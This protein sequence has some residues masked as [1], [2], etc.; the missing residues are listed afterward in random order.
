MNKNGYNQFKRAFRDA[1]ESLTDARKVDGLAFPDE[2]PST[3]IIKDSRGR[4]YIQVL[5]NN[6]QDGTDRAQLKAFPQYRLIDTGSEVSSTTTADRSVDR[7]TGTMSVQS[8][9]I[10]GIPDV[11]VPSTGS[12]GS[13]TGTTTTASPSDELVNANLNPDVTE[14]LRVI[15]DVGSR[16]SYFMD[17]TNANNFLTRD[18]VSDKLGMDSVSSNIVK[19]VDELKAFFF[20]FG[21]KI[22]PP[23]VNPYHIN[24]YQRCGTGDKKNDCCDQ[25][26]ITCDGRGSNIEYAKAPY[27]PH[28]LNTYMNCLETLSRTSAVRETS[29]T[30]EDFN[31]KV[32]QTALTKV[33]VTKFID[34][35]IDDLGVTR[36]QY[37]FN[38][39]SIML[40]ILKIDTKLF[41]I[42][43]MLNLHNSS[44]S[45]IT[46]AFYGKP[47][48]KIN[49]NGF[50]VLSDVVTST[51]IHNATLQML[52]LLGCILHLI[53]FIDIDSYNKIIEDH[54]SISSVGNVQRA[55]GGGS[56]PAVP[57]VI[58]STAQTPTQENIPTFLY[59]QL[60]S[61][62]DATR[63]VVN[64]IPITTITGSQYNP[65]K[66]ANIAY[67]CT[68]G[69]LAV[70]Q[71]I[72]GTLKSRCF[73]T[74]MSM[75]FPSG[76][77][78]SSTRNTT[79][80]GP[81]F[82]I[83]RLNDLDLQ[84][85]TRLAIDGIPLD[86]TK[87][88]PPK[89]IPNYL[90]VD[91]PICINKAIFCTI[92][93][94]ICG[95]SRFLWNS[96][97]PCLRLCDL[98]DVGAFDPDEPYPAPDPTT[99]TSTTS[100]TAPT[101]TQP[102]TTTTTSSSTT[103]QPPS[104]RALRDLNRGIDDDV[105][106]LDDIDSHFAR[107]RAKRATKKTG[108]VNFIDSRHDGVRHDDIGRDTVI[109]SRELYDFDDIPETNIAVRSGA[110]GG[111]NG[112]N[113]AVTTTVQYPFTDDVK[114][115]NEVDGVPDPEDAFSIKDMIQYLQENTFASVV[116]A[117][118]K[119]FTYL[120]L[121][122][123]AFASHDQKTFNYRVQQAS[124]RTVPSAV[125]RNLYSMLTRGVKF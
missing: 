41:N 37:Y 99:S 19:G 94:T 82:K 34:S 105:Y 17:P 98:D 56:T 15:N 23:G 122:I 123:S 83:D 48:T 101:T 92:I 1:K 95:I 73:A 65:S 12:S 21:K 51:D 4:T 24:E 50:P 45:P 30:Y 53:T 11:Y 104:T 33:K 67:N 96:N 58:D 10:D 114:P 113:R 88:I 79:E 85:I 28:D 43:Y 93:T 121:Y 106:D 112:S 89:S 70:A 69:L 44:R 97:S 124:A 9:R 68:Y 78:H 64:E 42:L 3:T 100:T 81:R 118:G 57:I 75:L 18:I 47:R 31:L 36:P 38:P 22:A 2:V 119:V 120:Q 5:P 74:V 13:S 116:T 61:F 91:D 7:S 60:L 32:F 66:V 25:I 102:P 20:D 40:E 29:D 107:S 27:N 39:M 62:C 52:D 110:R 87:V 46:G 76:V 90:P 77:L 108:R 72:E 117:N 80:W 54:F 59:G 49:E 6:R 103:A 16:I 35:S 84:S 14:F 71:L 8:R 26:N 63:Q 55:D 115:P 86:M 111:S 109:D 125:N